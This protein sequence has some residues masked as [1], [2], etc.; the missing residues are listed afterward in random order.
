MDLRGRSGTKPGS[1]LKKRIPV[2]TFA[3]WDEVRPGFLE[4]DLVSHDGG[5]ARGD[6]LNATDVR[7]GWTQCRAIQNR[8]EIWTLEALKAIRQELP[9]LGLDSDNGSE[10]INYHL[11]RYCEKDDRPNRK[12]AITFTRSRPC[13]KNDNCYVEQKNWTVIRQTVGY[14]RYETQEELRLLNRLYERLGLLGNYFQ[15]QMKLREKRREGSR[16]IRKYDD[17]QTPYARVL[18][19]PHV[20][21]EVKTRLRTTYDTLNPA[22]LRR[23]IETLRQELWQK[24]RKK[25]ALEST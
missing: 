1:L 12:G 17:P 9:L 25:P 18:A 10:F 3:Q 4:V 5:N 19:S 20:S 11:I 24:T 21:N 14:F 8:A 15:S 23:D 2:R 16:V 22:Q 7:T 6:C 13:K